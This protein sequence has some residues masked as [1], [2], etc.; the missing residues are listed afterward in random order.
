M[1]SRSVNRKGDLRG[2]RWGAGLTKFVPDSYLCSFKFMPADTA[3]TEVEQ[4]IMVIKSQN[5]WTLHV[6]NYCV[7]KM[8]L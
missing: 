6:L 8:F 5:C 7:R 4:V 2:W 3:V 1:G